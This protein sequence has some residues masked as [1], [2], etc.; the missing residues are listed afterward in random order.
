MIAQTVGDP[1][2]A[3][4]GLQEKK[5]FAYSAGKKPNKA[6]RGRP[7]AQGKVEFLIDSP[8]FWTALF[9]RPANRKRA[10]R[11]DGPE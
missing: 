7:Y 1:L 10:R 4:A 3:F 8:L 5:S 6:K 11:A 9:I 2:H